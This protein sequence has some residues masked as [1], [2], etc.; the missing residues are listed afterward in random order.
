MKS[1]WSPVTGFPVPVK[2]GGHRSPAG[3]VPLASP[4]THSL[5]LTPSQNLSELDQLSYLSSSKAF[6]RAFQSSASAALA[7]AVISRIKADPS[8]WQSSMSSTSIADATARKR[9]S[10]VAVCGHRTRGLLHLHFVLRLRFQVAS[11]A[12]KRG[13]SRL[14]R[15]HQET[16]VRMMMLASSHQVVNQYRTREEGSWVVKV[17]SRA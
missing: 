11:S 3:E 17:I 4:V 8:S 1:G 12:M 2:A 10:R 9:E 14:T 16:L 15:A 6:W 7:Q 5:G 13:T